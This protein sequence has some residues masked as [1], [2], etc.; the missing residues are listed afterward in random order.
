LNLLKSLGINFEV[1]DKSDNQ[2][3]KELNPTPSIDY[4]KEYGS[5]EDMKRVC[6]AWLELN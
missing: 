4:K 2:S 1:K 3:Y 6:K 5:F